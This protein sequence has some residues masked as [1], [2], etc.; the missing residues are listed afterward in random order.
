MKEIKDIIKKILRMVGLYKIW[1]EVFSFFTTDPR[2]ERERMD[3][4]LKIY[5]KFVK[6]GDVCFDIGANMGIITELLLKLEVKV[7]C[8][9]PQKD[10]LIILKK[11]FGDNENVF[12]VD[13]A[14]GEKEG[15]AEIAIC[16]DAPTISTMSD[17][18]KEAGRFSTN[19][20]WNKTQKVEMI[21]LDKLIEQYGMPSFCKI[22]VEGFE[23]SALKGLTKAIPFISFEFTKEFFEDAKTCINH[24]SSIG[25]AKFNCTFC[26]SEKLLFPNWVPS[27]E[28]ISKL[29]NDNNSSMAGDIYVSF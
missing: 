29:E 4:I 12:I 25:R 26:E 21:T 14:V 18:W 11:K 22:D 3:D 1:I 8:V 17:K 15:E 13:K 24:I 10:C 2:K 16:E 7:V 9:E 19:Y 28:L 6:K 27:E 20:E 23:V 5:S